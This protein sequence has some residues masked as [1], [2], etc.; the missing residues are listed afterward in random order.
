MMTSRA[1]DNT[2]VVSQDGDEVKEDEDVISIQSPSS[3]IL[4]LAFFPLPLILL[5]NFLLPP[6]IF[7]SLCSPLSQNVKK[8]TVPIILYLD[9]FMCVCVCVCVLITTNTHLW[10]STAAASLQTE[11]KE[12]FQ[13]ADPKLH[14]LYWLKFLRLTTDRY[15][16]MTRTEHYSKTANL[17]NVL[18]HSSPSWDSWIIVNPSKKEQKKRGKGRMRKGRL[19]PCT[20]SSTFGSSSRSEL[21]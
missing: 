17:M 11:A 15:Q 21:L 8:V 2:D 1:F 18:D 5:S 19:R 20:T 7:P 9:N 6:F 4:I 16:T 10:T 3:P 12:L 14:F 13:R